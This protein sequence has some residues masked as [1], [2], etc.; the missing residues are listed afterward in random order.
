[1]ILPIP[2]FLYSLA[3]Q[4]RS[5]VVSRMVL[6][7]NHVLSSEPV[8]TERLLPHAGARIQV[9]LDGWPTFLPP[10]SQVEFGITPA[11]LLEWFDPLQ[12]SSSEP[13]PPTLRIAVDVSRPQSM[14]SSMLAGQKPVVELT[15]SAALATDI[16]WVLEN[17]R[18]DLQ[19]DL[20]RWLGPVAAREITRVGSRA[21]TL[22]RAALSQV[23][24]PFAKAT[25]SRP[26]VS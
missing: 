18:W 24:R 10:W 11:G 2:S 6:L 12:P 7:I 15:G 20:S 3:N 23:I 4:G 5:A 17:V 22:L 14:V 9:Q 19:D 8:A 21:A 26:T 1:M 25:A 13:R 16:N